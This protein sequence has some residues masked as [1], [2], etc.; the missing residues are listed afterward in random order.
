VAAALRIGQKDLEGQVPGECK[1]AVSAL[2]ARVMI[3]TGA[4]SV[5][6]SGRWKPEEIGEAVMCGFAA[7]MKNAEW[8]EVE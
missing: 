7:A 1:K 2:N 5:R 4:T 3:D 6:I 8:K